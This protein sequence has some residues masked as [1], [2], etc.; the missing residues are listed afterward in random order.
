MKKFVSLFLAIIITA[1]VLATTPVHVYVN[2]ASDGSQYVFF[3]AINDGKEYAVSGSSHRSEGPIV[4]PATYN[5]K[6]VTKINDRA[7]FNRNITSVIIPDSIKE[8]EN[9]AF[10]GCAQLNDITLPDTPIKIGKDVFSNT[11]YIETDDNWDQD[12]LLYIGKHL[13]ATHYKHDTFVTK[14]D[15]LSIAGGVFYCSQIT[16][17]EITGNVKSIGENAFYNCQK[18]ETLI[19]HDGIEII[20]RNAFSYCSSLTNV[21]IPGSVS[22]IDEYVFSSCKN[23]SSVNVLEGV[24]KIESNAFDKSKNI[25]SFTL[26]ES[27]I[28][29]ASGIFNDTKIYNNPENW[30]NNTF[31]VDKHLISTKNYIY[32][33]LTI[34]EGTT[35]INAL[36]FSYRKELSSMTLP[37]SVKAIG[38]NA[39][40]DTNI[41]FVFYEGNETE[42]SQI[43]FTNNIETLSQKIIIGNA[44]RAQKPA[45]PKVTAA[46]NYAGGVKITWTPIQNAVA[47]AV[48]RRG[49]GTSN[50]EF[51]GITTETAAI[52]T[53][54]KHRQYWRYSVQAVNE[55]GVSA[56]DYNGK[57]L[58]YIATPVLKGLANTTNGLKLTWQSVPGASGYRVYRRGAGQ[59]TWTYL[60][61]VNSTTYTDTAV[62]NAG[63]K[64][65]R[66]T[67][68]AVV[69]GLYSGY[70]DYLYRMRLTTP[71]ISSVVYNGN[72]RTTISW[73][74][75]T[76]ATGYYIER[77]SPLYQQWTRIGYV[78]G[79]NITK[80]VDTKGDSTGIY[81]YRVQATS[82]NA[83]SQAS[84]TK[85]QK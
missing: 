26:P 11:L 73:K 47:Y 27:V 6:P 34:R 46:S 60:G 64:Y 17:A 36:A 43:N 3:T 16:S 30:E 84:A 10:G 24:T 53:T 12:G 56:F 62:K 50:W 35:N 42:F 70:E 22:V 29:I 65:Y 63:G 2:A 14:E 1:S 15:T 4:I 83:V 71:V 76:G 74:K 57:Y 39:F 19:L 20:A 21:T 66:Y 82:G 61:T 58:K 75:V 54:A 13:I 67:V 18:L 45:T 55:N 85:K 49:A 78:K 48:Y 7:F 38:E 9:D 68:R 79:G 81:S 41:V 28:S 59:R 80:F 8:I 44:N 31:Y 37:K 5:N 33:T 52:D 32:G 69:D 72:N 23:L 51:L 40:K 77:Y 25:E